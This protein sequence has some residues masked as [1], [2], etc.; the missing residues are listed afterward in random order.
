MGK[1]IEGK[2]RSRDSHALETRKKMKNAH[3][4]RMN[5]HRSEFERKNDEPFKIRVWDLFDF[6]VFDF[7]SSKKKKRDRIKNYETKYFIVYL[8]DK[9]KLPEVV[10]RI[11]KG[12]GD[13]R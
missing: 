12:F 5:Y 4:E 13:L 10:D 6:G 3:T 9:M 11:E 1:R 8:R 2:V 7:L